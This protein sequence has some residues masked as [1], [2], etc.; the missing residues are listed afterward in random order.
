MSRIAQCVFGGTSRCCSYIKFNVESKATQQNVY[1]IGFRN[2]IKTTLVYISHGS[3][4]VIKKVF[5]SS[6]REKKYQ[7]DYQ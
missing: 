3:M 2:K 1:F 7:M 5:F 4:R 6:E